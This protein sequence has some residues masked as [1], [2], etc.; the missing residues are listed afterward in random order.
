MAM[1]VAPQGATLSGEHGILMHCSNATANPPTM[2][3]S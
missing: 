1:R 3:A 2:E